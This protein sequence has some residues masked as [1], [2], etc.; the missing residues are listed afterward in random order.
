MCRYY[1]EGSTVCGSKT[2]GW[3]TWPTETSPM[4]SSTPLTS[5]EAK[6]EGK[7]RSHTHVLVALHCIDR[8][9]APIT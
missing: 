2:L 5:L 9:L 8:S 1:D 7:S 4:Q 3:L 6:V